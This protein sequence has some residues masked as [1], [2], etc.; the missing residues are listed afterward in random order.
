[1]LNNRILKEPLVLASRSPRRMEI[2]RAVGWPFETVAA[3]IDETRLAGEDAIN[4][5]RRLA[6]TKAELVATKLSGRLVLGAD[7]VVVVDGEI[8]G[9]PVDGADA[10][11]MLQLLSG[12]WHSVLTGVALVRVGARSLSLW[13]ITRQLKSVSLR[14]RMKRSIVTLS[15]ANRWIKRELMRFR[16]R[17]RLLSRR[18]RVTIS[19]LSVCQS[20]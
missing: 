15:Q 16:E 7:T 4:Y 5:V 14:S 13:L 11:R 1:M 18:F 6:Q 17:Q 3:G 8:L 2:L 20:G 9:Q 12:R 10:R 19:T